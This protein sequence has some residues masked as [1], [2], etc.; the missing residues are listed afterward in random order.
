VRRA[1]AYVRQL[2]TGVSSP[3][4]AAMFIHLR[5]REASALCIVRGAHLPLVR[6]LEKIAMLFSAAALSAGDASPL[7]TPLK[8]TS[9]AARSLKATSST[10]NR[11]YYKSRNGTQS[12][13]FHTAHLEKFSQ[14][15]SH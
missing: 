8:T 13:A 5:V 6:H 1:R 3:R 11:K 12:P 4:R 9:P 14:Y 7:A 10:N 2:S 15:L